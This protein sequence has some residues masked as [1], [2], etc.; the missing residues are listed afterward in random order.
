MTVLY[1]PPTKVNTAAQLNDIR[2]NPG[3]YINR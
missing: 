1:V 2:N 3:K